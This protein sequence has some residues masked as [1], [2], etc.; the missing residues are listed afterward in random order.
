MTQGCYVLIKNKLSKASQLKVILDHKYLGKSEHSF[1]NPRFIIGSYTAILKVF[2]GHKDSGWVLGAQETGCTV[3]GIKNRLLTCGNTLYYVS[4][5][6]APY[7]FLS[8]S[9]FLSLCLCLCLCLSISS[10]CY[11]CDV[12]I[13]Y[14]KSLLIGGHICDMRDHH[15]DSAMVLGIECVV[16]CL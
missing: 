11:C 12:R 16:S 3:S 6:P 4:F 14:I 5:L 9:P 15:Q 7:S 8:L 1:F 10:Y 13:S 2:W